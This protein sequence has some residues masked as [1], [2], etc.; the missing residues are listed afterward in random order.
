MRMRA[1]FRA[2]T[3]IALSLAYGLPAHAQTLTLTP[4][5]AAVYYQ[6]R[7]IPRDRAVGTVEDENP[8]TNM[9]LL[10]LT[11]APLSCMLTRTSTVSGTLVPGYT[12]IYQSGVPGIGIRFQHT[13]NLNGGFVTAPTTSTFGIPMATFAAQS[14]MR[15]SIV[16]TGPITTGSL[17]GPGPSMTMTITNNCGLPTRSTSLTAAGSPTATFTAQTCSVSSPS[18]GVTLPAVQATSLRPVGTTAANHVFNIRLSCP[19]G[20]RVGV[21]LT[22]SS[23]TANRSDQ[24]GLLPA[25]TAQG[26]K[27][28]ILRSTVPVLFGADSAVAGNPGQIILATSSTS[29][30]TDFGFAT[31]YI[32]TGTVVPGSVSAAATFTMSYQ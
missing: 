16:V 29:G 18:I 8:G 28:R 21:T 13:N 4:G 30:T 20:L 24:L 11:N 17:T 15:A 2:V 31:Q 32:S 26:V 25:S 5:S 6:S 3:A 10:T 19:A 23:N 14:Y 9:G 22:D 1:I 27:L 12:N 7:S